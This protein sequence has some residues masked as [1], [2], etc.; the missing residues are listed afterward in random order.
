MMKLTIEQLKSVVRRALSEANQAD[1]ELLTEP[2]ENEPEGEEEEQEEVSAG[3]VA[4]FALPLGMSPP[5]YDRAKFIKT[6]RDSFGGEE[7]E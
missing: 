3:G 5:G 2:D 4:G 1:D 6:A 7:D